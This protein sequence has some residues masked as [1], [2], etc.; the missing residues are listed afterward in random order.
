M[1][2]D[3]HRSTH[4]RESGDPAL[5]PRLRGDERED[6]LA[7][8]LRRRLAGF[9]RTLRSNGFRVGLAETSDALAVLA[10]PAGAHG[11]RR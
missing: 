9:A 8:P 6:S 4:S 1:S 7:A 5:G 11:L 10:S 3:A 2:A